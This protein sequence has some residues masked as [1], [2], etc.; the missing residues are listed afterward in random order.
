MCVLVGQSCLT[1]CEPM[2]CIACKAP[3]SMKF[4]RQEYWSGLPFLSP[5][6]LL[7]PGIKPQSPALQTDALPSELLAKSIP[8]VG[9]IFSRKLS[10]IILMF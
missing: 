6:D 8:L 3:L 9:C 5:G 7:N 1:L 4:F 10:I 2:N